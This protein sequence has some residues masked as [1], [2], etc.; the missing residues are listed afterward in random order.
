MWCMLSFALLTWISCSANTFL[1]QADALLFH[2]QGYLLKPKCFSTEESATIEKLVTN[3]IDLAIDLTPHTQEETA[4]YVRGSKIVYR[5]SSIVRINGCAG[6]ERQLQ[7]ILSSETMLR[8]FFLLLGV[9]DLEHLIEQIHPKLP[10]DGIAFPAHRD[11]QFRH[12]YDPDWTDVLDN[13]SYAICI[14][15]VDPMTKENG[16]LWIDP[17]SYDASSSE[18]LFW[19]E[20]EPGDLLFIHSYLLHGSGPNFSSMSRRTLLTGFCAFGT[21]HRTYPGAFVNI[22]YTLLNDEI[23]SSKAP[24]H[25]E[26]LI[27]SQGPFSSH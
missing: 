5:G 6:L 12:A 10:G 25:E 23:I 19:I 8:S 22:R 1:S 18:E 27:E 13:G 17:Q 9:D 11:I 4:L 3:V 26:E 15:P 21:N 16:G 24:W 20:A 2:R 7:D 14:I